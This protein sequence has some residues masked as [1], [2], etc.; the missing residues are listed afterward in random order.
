[1]ANVRDAVNDPELAA[2][3]WRLLSEEVVP[4]LEGRVDQPLRFAEQTV[5]RFRNPFLD[6][7]FADI[8][9]HHE[10]KMKVRLLPT[11]DEFTTKFGKAPPLLTEVIDE[12]FKQLAAG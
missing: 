12:G 1:V 4:A 3:L 2:W 7:K 5:E 8:A 6:H 11:R 9:L 10:S